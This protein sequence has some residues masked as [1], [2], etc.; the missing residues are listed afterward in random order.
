MSNVILTYGQIGT[1][2]ISKEIEEIGL[3]FT[4]F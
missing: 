4:M 1:Q 2:Q 3:E